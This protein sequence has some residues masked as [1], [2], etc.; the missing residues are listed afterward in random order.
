MRASEFDVDIAMHTASR[1]VRSGGFTLLELMVS[2]AVAAVILVL[3]LPEFSAILHKN[4][5]RAA[6]TNLYATMSLAR[7]EAIKRRNSVRVCPSAN[8]TSC[9]F[10]G[11]WT[12]GWIVFN[13]AD[14][15]GSPS[16][17]EI[18]R[19]VDFVHPQL[20]IEQDN[21][22]TAF[23]QFNATGDAFGTAGEF[24]ICHTNTLVNAHA[25]R[26]SPAGRLEEVVRNVVTCV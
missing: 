4:R 18:I 3:A 24:R 9:R 7:N 23:V 6:S 21:T 15:N 5:V 26:V 10:D 16:A 17:A 22:V 12:G 11:V 25:V 14:G 8:G 13:N 20:D 2:L 1:R 19:R